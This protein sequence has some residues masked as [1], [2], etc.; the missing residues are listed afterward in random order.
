MPPLLVLQLHG[1]DVVGH[2]ESLGVHAHRKPVE[3]RQVE[4]RYRIAR[5]L[6][7]GIELQVAEGADIHDE[8]RSGDLHVLQVGEREF[9][10]GLRESGSD[11]IGRAHV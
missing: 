7:A 4:D 9:R 3:L 11:E 2:T 1:R 8:L 5:A 6:L 10:C